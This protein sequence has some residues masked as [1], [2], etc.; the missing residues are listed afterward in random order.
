MD[1]RFIDLYDEYIHSFI[2]RRSFLERLT[3]MAGGSAAAAGILPLIENDMSKAITIL[4]TDPRITTAT[5]PIPGGPANFS[6]YLV[7][8]TYVGKRKPEKMPAIILVSENRST[9][10]NIKDICRRWGTE[11]FLVLGVDYLSP[12]GGNPVDQ[13]LAG[14]M[15]FK[16]P[17]SSIIEW[18]QVASNYLKSRPDV[19]KIGIL[20]FCWGG[21]VVNDM[22]VE[23][24]NLSAAVGYY[25][26]HP[27]L[28]KVH[29]ITAPLLMHYAGKDE[30][31]LLKM[32]A[33]DKALTEAGKQHTF[34]I[35][36]GT[37]HGFFNDTN[38]TRW[39]PVAGQLAWDRSLAFLKKY[40]DYPA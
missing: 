7:T 19:G 32:P 26:N 25:G 14:T 36:P 24:R 13:E 15:T 37:H 8:P 18:F 5:V 34:Y 6:G 17:K 30:P 35:Y 12:V 31:I 10:P 4:E 16:I 28:K 22:L 40:L 2:D 27:D 38:S 20:G 33:Y 9:N 1:Q 29:Q 11:G 3:V 23:D 39:D 21:D